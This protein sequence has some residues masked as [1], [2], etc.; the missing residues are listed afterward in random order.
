MRRKLVVAALAASVL[1]GAAGCGGDDG[2]RSTEEICTDLDAATEPLVADLNTTLA[3]AGLAA[4]QGDDAALAEAV[5]ELNNVV[6][7]ITGAV[8]DAAED[9]SDD[10][11]RAALD[12]YATELENLPGQLESG[13]LPDPAGVLAAGDGVAQYCR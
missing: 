12:S 9:A 1:A 7:Q 4:G 3:E 6:G 8:R 2:D 10:E 13:N 5:V 11:F